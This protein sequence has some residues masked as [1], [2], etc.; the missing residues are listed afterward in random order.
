MQPPATFAPTPAQRRLANYVVRYPNYQTVAEIC[1]AADVDPSSYYKWCHDP[2]FRL[3]FIRQWSSALVF[4]G[5]Q[6]LNVARAN[7]GRSATHFRTLV[8]LIFDP[9]GQIA[10]DAWQEH[11]FAATLPEEC[12]SQSNQQLGPENSTFLKL[13]GSSPSAT[14]AKVARTRPPNP[15]RVARHA[16]R[17]IEIA[18]IP[19]PKKEVAS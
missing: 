8:S 9:K 1:H 13:P 10:L 19:T 17:T 5:W 16:Q 3:W 11:A 18:A 14:S 4:E 12:D 7:M 15:N 6:I 2:D